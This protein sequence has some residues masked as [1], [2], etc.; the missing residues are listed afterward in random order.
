MS[1]HEAS[2]ILCNSLLRLIGSIG[3][4]RLLTNGNLPTELRE[5][6]ELKMKLDKKVHKV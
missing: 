2:I 6:D 5:L 4:Y 1:K 3:Y